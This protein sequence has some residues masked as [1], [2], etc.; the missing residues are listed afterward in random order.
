[1]KRLVQVTLMLSMFLPSFARAQQQQPKAAP[2]TAFF[3]AH[4]VPRELALAYDQVVVQPDHAGDPLQIAKLGAAPVAYFS[5]GELAPSQAQGLPKEFV[6]ARNDAWASLVM[7]LA[8]AKFRAHLLERYEALWS[9]GYRRFFLDTLD[10]YQLAAKTDEAREKQRRGLVLFLQA[11]KARHADVHLIF[12]RGFELMPD[13]AKIASGVVAESL[14]DRYD[15]GSKQYVRVPAADRTWLVGKLREVRDKYKLPVIVIDYRP[16]TERAEARETAKRIAKLGF[17][18][19]VCNGMLS[20]VGVGRYELYPRKVLILTDTPLKDGAPIERTGPL[21]WLA[22]VLEYQGYFSE[23]RSVHAGLP[24]APLAGRYAGVIT[25]FEGASIP[26]GYGA[27]MV[28]QIRGGSRFAVFG[29]LGFDPSSSEARE[30][31]LRRARGE[32]RDA[33]GP[34]LMRDG[35]IGFEAE[36]PAH[37]IAGGGLRLEGPAAVS[38]LQVIDQ[39]GQRADAVATA[40]WGGIAVSHVFAMRGLYGER[41]W[42][43]D[44]FA[45]LARAL[46]F[47][48]APVPDVTTENGRRLAMFVIEPDGLGERARVR[49]APY[50]W[51]VLRDEILER[52]R[53]PHAIAPSASGEEVDAVKRLLQLPA[54]YAG[55]LRGGETDARGNMAS[56]T[57]VEAMAQAQ[58]SGLQIPAPIAWDS[59]FVPAGAEGYPYQRVIETLEYTDAPRRLKPIALHYHAYLASSPA[60]IEALQRIYEYVRERDVQPIRASD[61][62]A[63]VGAFRSQVLVRDLDGAWSIHGGPELRTVRVPREL[64]EPDVAASSGVVSVRT[65]PQGCYVSFGASGPRKLVLS[66]PKVGA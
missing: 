53:W 18:P 13:V 27:W 12:N 48:L 61:Y 33:K 41:A 6:L 43:L 21:G 4:D 3:Y 58:G 42:V 26:S 32:E 14:F 36:P 37:P 65:L 29:A 38:H 47:P 20:D 49:G 25:Y 44:P 59:A 17:E 51:S 31:G 8:N 2:S 16:E 40:A 10:S 35:M 30:L 24:E 1:M 39:V 63:S 55:T 19:W 64:G 57:R 5:V 56:L 46:Q 52:Y 34:I 50:T 15:A 54:A 45:F 11:M 22:P 23:L 62:A 28:S 7:D 9:R 60:G 66:K